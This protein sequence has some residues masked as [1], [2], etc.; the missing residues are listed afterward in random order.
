MSSGLGRPVLID[1]TEVDVAL[2]N[3]AL[4]E[5]PSPLLHMKLQSKLIRQIASRFGAPKNVIQPDDVL[6][7]RK[8]IEAWMEGFPDYFQLSPTGKGWGKVPEWLVFHRYYLWT[9]AYLMILNPI[10]PFMAKTYDRSSSKAE[11]EIYA[12]GLRYARELT[13]ALDGW[14]NITVHRDGWFHFQIFSVFDVASMLCAAIKVDEHDM[15]PERPFVFDAIDSNLKMLRR[16]NE[17]SQTA[18]VWHD[19]L[20][21]QAKQLPRPLETPEEAQRKRVRMEESRSRANGAFGS[22]TRVKAE[23]LESTPRTW[24]VN[25]ESDQP[26]QESELPGLESHISASISPSSDNATEPQAQPA[27]YVNEMQSQVDSF[28]QGLDWTFFQDMTNENGLDWAAN[29]QNFEAEGLFAP[30]DFARP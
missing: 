30:T 9:M 10:R 24:A 22:I 5:Q 21:R 2:P 17:V 6:E 28:S 18:G 25:R 7:Y 1:R 8:M 15:I 19:L 14:V 11:L 13:M 16:L 26:P 12:A 29:W 20:S 23:P 27:M 4:E 3:L